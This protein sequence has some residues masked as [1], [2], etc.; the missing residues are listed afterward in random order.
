[1]KLNSWSHATYTL[2]AA[3]CYLSDS[4]DGNEESREKAQEEFMKVWQKKCIRI[5]SNTIKM[6]ELLNAKK[7][8]GRNMPMED[9]GV[10][11][12]LFDFTNEG[13]SLHNAS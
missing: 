4:R 12:S 5:P 3:G 11:F 6:P 13:V 9:V 2:L 1:M 7:L 8:G 10:C